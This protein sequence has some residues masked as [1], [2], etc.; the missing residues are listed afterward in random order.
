MLSTSAFIQA[1]I[2]LYLMGVVGLVARKMKVLSNHANQVMTQL[3][4][5]ITLPALI[6]FSLNTEFS[7]ELI[8][9]FFWLVTMSIFI[10]SI[11]IIIAYMLRKKAI[12]P[13]NRKGVYESLIVFGNQGFIGFAVAYI[14]MSDQGI[15]YLTFFNICYLILIW[16]YGIHLFTKGGRAVNWKL[17]FLNPGIL[18]TLTGLAILFLPFTLPIVVINTLEDIGK[19]TIPLS[20]LLIGSMI[21]DIPRK[22]IMHFINNGYIWLAACFKLLLLPL[23]LFIFLFISV[24]FPLL[25]IAVLTAGMPSASTT[26]V[27]AQKFGGDTSFA[28]FGVMHSTLLCVLS[29]PVLYLALH[30]LYI[31]FP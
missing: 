18:A 3:M 6:L 27:Y 2:P 9:D 30:W 26:S 10:L 13:N 14:L 22:E 12:L 15:I 16:T 5:Y 24:P 11:S 1:M 23:F 7:I 19:V 4:L 17:L 25:T 21:A 8:I 20:M 29:I 31:Y 28:S